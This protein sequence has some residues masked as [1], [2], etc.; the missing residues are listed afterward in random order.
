MSRLLLQ[1]LFTLHSHH[2]LLRDHHCTSIMRKFFERMPGRL[3]PSCN[4]GIASVCDGP[5]WAS[6]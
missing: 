4:I 3:R 5:F 1:Q 2:D 6:F